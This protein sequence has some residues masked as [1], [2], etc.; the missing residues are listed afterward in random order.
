M[1]KLY[2]SLLVTGIVAAGLAGC[3]DDVTITEPPPPPPPPPPSI[4][5]VTVA[6]NNVQVAPG[7]DIQMTAAVTSDAG[8]NPT[9][10]WGVSDATR[11]SVSPSGLVSILA[12]AQPG[13]VAIRATATCAAGGGTG[14]GAA[15]LNVTAG[16]A[17][18]P[19]VSIASV[20]VGVVPAALAAIAGQINVVLNL[21]RNGAAVQGLDLFIDTQT[22]D[23]IFASQSFTAPP[24][25]V[26]DGPEAAVEVITLSINT[27]AFNA[28]TG[29]VA[30]INRQ[31][32]LR[33]RVRYGSGGQSEASNT[34]TVQ[35]TT[36]NGNTFTGTMS[37][38]GGFT[39][40][41]N[42]ATGLSFVRGGL[43]AR[44]I[45]VIY[46]NGLSLAAGTVSFGQGCDVG[47]V[48]TATL[49]APAAGSAEWT[50]SF[51]NTGAP[52]LANVSGYEYRTAF[53]NGLETLRISGTDN[54]GNILFAFTNPGAGT[55]VAT[56]IR[57]DNLGPGAPTF[58]MNP[59]GRQN[60]WINAGV[61]LV[62]LNDNGAGAPSAT[63]NDWLRNGAADA[64]V[65]GY[66]R[67]LRVDATAPTTVTA[68]NAATPSASPTLPNPSLNP[69]DYCAVASAVD[70]LGNE[71]A[72][73]I[74]VPATNCNVPVAASFQNTLL[75]HQRF[76]VDIDAPTIAF[77]ASPIGL[78][79][80]AAI[81]GANIGNE[82][83]L[84]VA[85]IGSI[86]V[87]G[88]L[89]GSPV[90]G[91]I[92]TL[93]GTQPGATNCFFPAA[94]GP[95]GAAT[96]SINAAPALPLVPTA[97]AAALTGITVPAYYTGTFNAIDAAGNASGS[98]TRS[99]VFDNAGGASTPVLTA[100]L[101]NTPVSGPSVVFN[102]LASDNLDLATL[103]Y[104]LGYSGGLAGPIIYPPATLNPFPPV[105]AALVNSNV[106]AA[107][108]IN[109]FM[110][111]LE[112][113][114]NGA[115]GPLTVGGPFLPQN[116][117]GNLLDQVG[118]SSGPIGTV[119]P[120]ASVTPGISFVGVAAAQQ[121]RDWRISAPAAAVNI[122]DGQAATPANPTSVVIQI[123]A[124]G[125]T[126]T[127]NTPFQ[128]VDLF[129]FDGANLN[130]IGV[131]VLQPTFDDGSAFGRRH[132]YL[133]TWTPG[134]GLFNCGV[135]PCSTPNIN[136]Y[137][138][139]VSAAGDGLVT[140]VNTN[141]TL[142]N[143]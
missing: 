140:Q 123:D 21:E 132:R 121:T 82:F 120:P 23:S 110:R 26:G 24:A 35:F 13:A 88:M 136:I 64:G 138:V 104:T 135:A 139:G 65:G 16:N 3:G 134:S 6:P 70:A 59:N 126:A 27:A 101:F 8:C 90:V 107:V 7:Q 36:V 96:A 42:A 32:T 77:A 94:V 29:Q 14:S 17:N 73:P 49:A 75:S 98:V 115:G 34:N 103:Q 122:S 9:V 10:T 33:G 143:P 118:N 87:S 4:T 31:H 39:P 50:A 18:I 109:G 38:T 60:G 125:P 71:S 51:A 45:P 20:N 2:R 97:G 111:R 91:N 58:I 85:D 57:L 12:T 28:T 129:A 78:Q 131:G 95:C 114:T 112:T 30:L 108:T 105:P 124:F 130:Q 25:T 86:G 102:A 133:F 83:T 141:I 100:A 47:G 43:D 79:A 54:N 127:F 55:P 61:G 67:Q 119:I 48:R 19:T 106:N 72:L 113:V 116:L 63:D 117:T 15:T 5:N 89:A 68:A 99:I 40:A 41:L 1:N 22:G 11:A 92:Q 66:T 74:T 128:R 81:A 142:T 137:A 80:N 52:A 53:C 62:G 37:L 93:N 56:G 46:S 44:V 76:G 69:N 84:T